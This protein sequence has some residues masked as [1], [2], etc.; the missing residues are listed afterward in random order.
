MKKY[1]NVVQIVGYIKYLLFNDKYK[2]KCELGGEFYEK[3]WK[4]SKVR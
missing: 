3:T 4:K 2:M 1:R